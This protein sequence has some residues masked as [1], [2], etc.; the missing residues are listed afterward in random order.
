MARWIGFAA[1]AACGFALASC[2]DGAG[3][4]TTTVGD[5]TPITFNLTIADSGNVLRVR[6]GDEVVARLPLTGHQDVG[7]VVT[8]SPNPLVL[9]GGDDLRFF[10]SETD[11]GGVAYHEFSF[12]AVG[13]GRTT[14]TLTHGFQQFTFTVQVT[15]RN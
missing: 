8:V 7:W 11:Q 6:P 5:P 12:V 3:T 1:L 2:G 10:P 15:E 14:V 4:V 13:P 9:G